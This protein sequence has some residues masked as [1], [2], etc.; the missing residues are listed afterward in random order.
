MT[1]QRGAGTLKYALP[2]EVRHIEYYSMYYVLSIPSKSRNINYDLSA[3]SSDN[4]CDLTAGSRDI[5]EDQPAE[6][7]DI[8]CSV[9]RR[10]PQKVDKRMVLVHTHGLFIT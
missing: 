10:R 8:N 7:M 6:S 2:S 1:Y 9:S 5:T 4:I 3:E